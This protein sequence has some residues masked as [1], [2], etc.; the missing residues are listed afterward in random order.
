MKIVGRH[1]EPDDDGRVAVMSAATIPPAA[2]A[3]QDDAD[4]ALRL[5]PGADPDAVRAAAV[6]AGD[7][8]ASV[9]EPADSLRS[10]AADM[11]PI[12]YGLTALLMLIAG[13]N[14]LTTLLLGVRERR[15]DVA[16]LSAVG[17]TPRQ[18]AATV[19][20]GGTLLA[21]P[22]AAVGLPLGAWVFRTLISSTDPS[23][24][25]DVVTM[26]AVGWIVLALPVAIALTAAVASLAGR[27]A[28]RVPAAAALRAE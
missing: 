7:G 1:V 3:D 13:V 12:V 9:A 27:Q 28:A 5:A 22:A 24:G 19:I 2:I 16:V 17:A 23:D 14:L 11:R 6:A 15:R 10:E 8:R 25:P 4:W 18:V 21:L 20:A 26:P